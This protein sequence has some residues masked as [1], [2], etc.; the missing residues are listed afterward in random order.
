M[1][2]LT[3]AVPCSVVS[4]VSYLILPVSEPVIRFILL[5]ISHYQTFMS[6]IL[7]PFVI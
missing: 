4:H 7:I 1:Q 5:I 3:D 2:Y 6:N